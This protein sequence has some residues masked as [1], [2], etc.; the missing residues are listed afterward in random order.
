MLENTLSKLLLIS[1]ENRLLLFAE[2]DISE[3]TRLRSLLTQSGYA[4]FDYT[5]AQD[6]RIIYEERIRNS[7]DKIAVIISSDIYVPYDIRC[8]LFTI[9]ISASTIFPN[10]NS[11]VLIA[12]L[13]DW[14]IISFAAQSSYSDCSSRKQTEDFIKNVVFSESV[15]NYYC[16]AAVSK[17]RSDCEAAASYLDWIQ[18]AK[19][20]AS[21]EY[22]AAMK[23]ITLDIL[24]VDSF[25]NRFIVNGYGR[26]STEVCRQSPPIVT[27]AFS[28]IMADNNPKS[29]LIV[30]DGMS[31]FD[32]KAMSYHFGDIQYDYGCSYAL[33]PT[34]TPIS[35]QS[36]LSGKFPRELSKPFSLVNEEKDFKSMVESYGVNREQIEYLRGYDAEIRPLTKVAAII[37]NEVDEIVHGQRQGRT[38]MYGDMD[39]LGS[40]GKLQSLISRLTALGFTVYITSDHG[41]TL[42]TGIGSFRSGVEMESRSKRM[43]VLKDFAEANALLTENATEYQGFYLDKEYRYFICKSGTSFDNKG[44]RVMTHGGMSLDEVIVPFIKVRR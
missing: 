8:S 29:A 18:I 44:E 25:F 13:Q 22:Y 35:R 9:K 24:F 43:A 21:I 23:N 2:N 41:N 31:L 14:D 30:M 39:L 15:I 1:K 33:I 38:G 4:L 42:C 6:F 40:N 3:S 20:K 5:D 7:N 36:L 19:R 11:D 16:D 26:L 34:T 37:I 12:Y 28:V 27:K 32:F 10:L 17:L